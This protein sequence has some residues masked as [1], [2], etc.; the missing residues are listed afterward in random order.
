MICEKCPAKINLS[1]DIVG[2]R[3][4]GYHLVDMIMLSVGLCD[5]V[6]VALGG[7]EIQIGCGN[8]NV[9]LGKDNI[10]YK[11]AERFLDAAGIAERGILIN[12]DKEVPIGAGLAGGSADA[13]GVLRG[14]N[15]LFG[16]IFTLEKLAEIGLS[17]G[18]DV[19]FCIGGGCARAE[20]IGEVLTPLRCG[21][22]NPIVIAKPEFEVSTVQAY[23]E[24]D[25]LT[26]ISHPDTG[27]VIRV[28][29]EGD[30]ARLRG[31][32]K[33]VLEGVTAGR[34]REI[35]E[36]KSV[37]DGCGALFSIM[38]GS[39]P[40]VVGIF[41]GEA[42]AESAAEILRRSTREVFVTSAYC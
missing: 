27:A 23:R 10:C 1:L 24:Y 40:S 11:A 16:N 3:E 38:S 41:G 12:I 30:A 36:Y 25:E 14:L 19:P 42:E 33:N 35:N 28:V 26:D 18:A 22:K 32:A 39:G 29:S 13:A 8:A 34:H 7:G 6:S 17:V 5:T 37:M 20:G 21:L 9:P 15:R 4:D 31:C 2:R